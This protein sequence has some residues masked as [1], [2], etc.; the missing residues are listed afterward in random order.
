MSEDIANSDIGIDIPLP[1]YR[2]RQAFEAGYGH[3]NNTGTL[4][5]EESPWHVDGPADSRL[6]A[7]HRAFCRGMRCA[8]RKESPSRALSELRDGK[9]E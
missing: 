2:K 1:F 4:R 8:W 3:Y 5:V 7:L 6:F 9:T